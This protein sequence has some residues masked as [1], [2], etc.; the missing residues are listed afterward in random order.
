MKWIAETSKIIYKNNSMVK[1]VGVL[2]DITLQKNADQKIKKQN[3][4]LQELN[5]KKDKFFSIIAHDLKNPFSSMLG[6]SEILLRNFEDY[7]VDKQKQMLS[8][9]HT[10]IKASYKLLDNLLIWSRSQR[11][12]MTFEPE[13]AN[14]YILTQETI[15]LLNQFIENKSIELTN[16]I[17][18]T[19]TVE[20][21]INM[22]ATIIRNL[23]T[24]AVKFTE[25]GGM[26]SLDAK[27]IAKNNTE[28]VK[29]AV[30]D[31]GVG[32][33]SET[34]EKLFKISENVSTKGTDKETGTG[35][36]LVICK[37]FVEKH[38][39]ELWV[40]SQIGN[41]SVFYFTVPL[42]K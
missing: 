33:T 21:D 31:N 17:S 20:A 36:G 29:I 11:G 15:G 23:L 28:F 25:Y 8:Y 35:L 3:N 1:M 7:D 38:G 5:A 12:T 18:E 42:A 14:L 10:S 24:N 37:D 19:I 27:I 6:F 2:Q 32:M 9:I 41:G 13:N 16:N 34:I 40:E 22:L 39:G 30:K 4:K 26:V